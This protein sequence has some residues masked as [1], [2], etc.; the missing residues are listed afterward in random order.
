LVG[1]AWAGAAD[2]QPTAAPEAVPA[3][4]AAAN[5]PADAADAL[6]QQPPAERKPFHLYAGLDL[7]TSYVSRGIVFSDQPS[8]Q[9]WAELDVPVVRQRE[10]GFI[11]SVSAFAGT[12]SSIHDGAEQVGETRSGNIRPLDNVYETDLYAGVRVGFAEHFNSSLRA[13]YY[14]SPSDSWADIWELDWRISYDD[15]HHWPKAWD[16]FQLNP[17][18]R[19]AKEIADDGGPEG[20][21]FRP[22]IQPSYTFT[23]MKQPLT[24][25]V[26]VVLGL[27]DNGQY[28]DAEGNDITFGMVR[29]GVGV[30]GPLDWLP[31][32]SGHLSWSAGVDVIIVTD[33]DINF[34]R[35]RVTTVGKVGLSYAY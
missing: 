22:Q 7:V 25:T 33:R 35:D 18:L 19:V 2:G 30:S 12:W 10:A 24:V 29:T 14:F 13:N 15:A 3:G 11:D 16:G 31:E 1:G 21:F 6:A 26:P 32:G 27:G 9:P 28:R 20:W 34:E 8:A 17:S 5:E 23:D 4:V